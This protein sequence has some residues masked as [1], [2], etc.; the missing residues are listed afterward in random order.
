M[1]SKTITV[2]ESAYHSIKNLK[3][4]GESFSDLFLRIGKKTPSI[5]K[6]VGILS[7]ESGEMLEKEVKKYRKELNKGFERRHNALFG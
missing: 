4:D 7:E 2:T 6:Y 3:Q 1:V 5:R